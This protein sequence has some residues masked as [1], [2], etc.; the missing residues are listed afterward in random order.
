MFIN[1]YRLRSVC[2]EKKSTAIAYSLTNYK[3]QQRLF[4]A[5][6][7]TK[8]QTTQIHIKLKIKKHKQNE[9]GRGL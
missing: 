6:P 3:N 9:D 8:I 2:K 1:L 5:L 4:T 7:T